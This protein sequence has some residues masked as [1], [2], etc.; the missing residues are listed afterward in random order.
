MDK[1]GD[2]VKIWIDLENS[3]HAL[4]FP[5]L[6]ERLRAEGDQVLVTARDCAQTFEL[7]DLAGVDYRGV[8]TQWRGP[9]PVKAAGVLGRSLRLA[10]MMLGQGVQV[11]ASHSSRSH[12][13]ASRLL[14][15]PVVTLLDYEHAAMGVFTRFSNR[16]LV[17]DRLPAS[18][19][20]GADR[21][22]LRVIPYPGFKE[23][24]Y[25][26]PVAPTADARARLGLNPESIVAVVRPPA[27]RAH[28]HDP[29]SD[30]ALLAVLD[31]IATAE[32]AVE[33]LIL[34][35]YPEQADALAQNFPPPRF[36]ILRQSVPFG[37]LLAVA[38]LV[39]SGG[40]TMSREA[41]ASGV[42]AYSLFQGRMGAVD[43]ALID[44]GR[45]V[46]LTGEDP[47]AR[48]VLRRRGPGD[49]LLGEGLL[50]FL[51]QEIRRGAQTGRGGA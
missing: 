27:T 49:A 31:R 35:R 26:R 10:A 23:Q 41:V 51:V 34:P 38:D 50:E 20:P 33:A 40:G 3:P 30:Q 7:L 1:E 21:D 8:G 28:Y 12:V 18:L 32:V 43:L 6:I 39:V 37:D 29:A 9:A 48:L 13:L 47:A 5:P 2:A 24:V 42:P 17:P 14:G 44:E 11:S 4:F 22:G 15:I 45:L 25:A 36:R 46:H 19:I 16:L